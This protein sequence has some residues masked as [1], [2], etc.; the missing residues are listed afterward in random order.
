MNTISKATV[1]SAVALA[2]AGGCS[3][4]GGGGSGG[5]GGGAAAA[6]QQVT[7]SGQQEVPPQSTGASGSGTV[8]VASDCSVQARVTV[9]GMTGTAAH[10]HHAKAGANGPVIVPFTKSGDNT[11]VAPEGAKMTPEQCAAYRAGD[12]RS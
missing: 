8:T 10:I 1:A 2:L 9:T 7:L 5:A 12:G 6:G 3:M 4:M 11:F